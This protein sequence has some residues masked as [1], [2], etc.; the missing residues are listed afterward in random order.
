VQPIAIAPEHLPADR[1]AVDEQWL[2]T[3]LGQHPEFRSDPIVSASFSPLGD[4]LGQMS[5]MLVARA[6]RAS[7]DEVPLVVKLHT[8]VEGM[9]DIAIRY[10]HYLRETNFYQQ[11]AHEV[12]VRT[13]RIYAAA[14]DQDNR[15]TALVMEHVGSTHYSPDQVAGATLAEVELAIDR[16]ARLTASFW[17]SPLRA[18]HSWM[19][20]ANSEF[21][22]SSLTD[23]PNSL[24]EALRR[25]GHAIP[26]MEAAA[27]VI[28]ANL[29]A[30]HDYLCQGPQVLTHWDYRVEN[31]FFNRTDPEDFVLLDWQLMI[32]M[33]PGWDFI[34]LVGTCMEKALRQQYFDALIDRYL[35]Q[36]AANGV[37]GYGRADFEQDLRM[38]AMACTIVPVVG[39][40]GYDVTNERSTAL[41]AK[42]SE[43]IF[44]AIDDLDALSLLR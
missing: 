41:F 26:G 43:R 3:T 35:E 8:T 28:G 27:R 10:H 33:R 23:Y 29:A 37:A 21:Y 40:A 25:F 30:I 4:G 31:M 36:L 5:E 11:L 1:A 19:G 22:R 2:A 32:W 13:P 15:R 24:D 6:R 42:V 14:Y 20:N 16:L 38:A 18:T 39:G 34:Y 12:P 17:D 44:S 9:R 7:G